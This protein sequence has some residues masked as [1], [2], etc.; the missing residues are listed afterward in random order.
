MAN[1]KDRVKNV[2]PAET[3]AGV[4][5]VVLDRFCDKYDNETVYEPGQDLEF[6][7]A[8]AKDVVERGLAKYLPLPQLLPTREGSGT[9]TSASEKGNDNDKSN[10]NDKNGQE[11]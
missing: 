4:K 2:E 10:D 9:G 5:I 7:A 8:R 1:K 11:Q 6:D 3:K